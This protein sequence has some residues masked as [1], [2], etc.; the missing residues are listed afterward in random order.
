MAE[1]AIPVD[2]FNPGQVFACHGFLEAT[3][4]LIGG[5]EGCFDWADERGGVATF[6]LRTPNSSNPTAEVLEFLASA[7]VKA[8]APVASD[9]ATTKWGVRTI[10]TGP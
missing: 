9:N 10:N 6:R 7:E 4:R 1:H 5:A 2:L 3:E 8:I